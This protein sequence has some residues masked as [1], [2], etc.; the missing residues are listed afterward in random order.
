MRFTVANFSNPAYDNSLV[1]TPALPAMLNIRKLLQEGRVN[2]PPAAATVKDAVSSAS[3]SQIIETRFGPVEFNLAQPILFSRGLLGMPE[4]QR[5][6]LAD[7]PNARFAHFKLLQSLD[8]AALSFITLPL[9]LQPDLLRVEDLQRAC[10]DAGIA[11]Q[12]L[13]V[14]LIVTVYR[15]PGGAEAAQAQLSVN[16]RAPILVDVESRQ[17]LQYVFPS[18]RYQVQQRLKTEMQKTA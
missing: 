4:K 14:L 16:C 15:T 7:F 10:E 11:F 18:D 13:A 2:Q 8:D 6:G 17:A 3:Q 9:E 12:N 5:F 1:A